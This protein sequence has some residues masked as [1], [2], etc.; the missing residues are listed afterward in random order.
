MTNLRPSCR[1]LLF[2]VQDGFLHGKFHGGPNRS[3]T[4]AIETRRMVAALTFRL[5]RDG[6]RLANGRH[7]KVELP[8]DIAPFIG[9]IG[10]FRWLRRR[11]GKHSRMV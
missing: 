8:L 6:A 3:T 10:V 5:G 11:E 9:R 1:I 4:A 2:A 7:S